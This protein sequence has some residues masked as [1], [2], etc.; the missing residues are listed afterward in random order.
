MTQ[1]K[2]YNLSI[3]FCLHV[4]S[5]DLQR[6][7]KAGLPEEGI[8]TAVVLLLRRSYPG[9][10]PACSGPEGVLPREILGIEEVQN[11]QDESMV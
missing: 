5:K 3:S 8:L 7:S 10:C 2:G 6:R 11:K 9:C 4:A 1:G